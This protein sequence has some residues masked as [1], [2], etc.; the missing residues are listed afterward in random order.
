MDLG[1]YSGQS[2]QPGLAVNKLKK[3]SAF[4]PTF[5][6][7][8]QVSELFKKLDTLIAF[9]QQELTTFKHTK[10]GFLQ[11]MFPKEGETVPEIRFPGFTGDW[12]WCRLGDI[13]SVAMCKR[14]FKNETKASGDVPFFKIGTFG[15]KPDSFISRQLF[16]KY[17]ENYPYPE[18]GD[19]LIS[20]SG[21]IGRTVICQGEDAYYQ[22]SNI[23]WLK[24]DK[25]QIENSFLKQF[26][27]IVKWAGLEGSTIKRLYN[28]NVLST[29]IS[30]PTIDEQTKIGN[31]FNQLDDTITL[32]Q[33]ELD[34]LKQTKKAFLQKMFI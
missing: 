10:Q 27:N 16:E 31:F 33:R 7:Q 21:T 23:I 4:I 28:S 9:Y 19:I 32:H 8:A 18:I 26:Y 14:I 22:D 5:A 34:I 6:E 25:R 1:Q 17:K 15:G 20:A 2:A 29:M 12:K 24:R 13:G 11:K 3:L 30:L